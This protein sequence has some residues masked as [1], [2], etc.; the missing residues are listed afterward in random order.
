ML[1]DGGVRGVIAIAML[2][3]GQE[4][5][6]LKQAQARVAFFGRSWVLLFCSASRCC[7]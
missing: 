6:S 4:G 3:L 2:A 7:S 1:V 5:Y